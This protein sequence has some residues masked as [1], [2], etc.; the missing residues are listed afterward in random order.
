MPQRP[1]FY[2]FATTIVLSAALGLDSGDGCRKSDNPDG[3]Q[4]DG[5]T[6][7]CGTVSCGQGEI[8]VKDQT[9]GGAFIPP[10]DAGNCPP[11]RII[12][13]EAPISCSPPPTF[14]CAPLPA[15]CLAAPSCAC[16]DTL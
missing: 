3:G 16:A 9:I 5:S 14:H 4:P 7:S 2:G 13:P 8:C 15:A 1:A 10:D 11:P 12:V 6:P